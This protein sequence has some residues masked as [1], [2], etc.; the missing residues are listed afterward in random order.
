M[1][2]YG[3]APR[4]P[5]LPLGHEEGEKFMQVLKPVLELEASLAA[6]DC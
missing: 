5:L 3:L 6:K 1:H 4:K 2:E